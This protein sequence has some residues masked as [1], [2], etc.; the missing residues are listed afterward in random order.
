[1]KKY[2]KREKLLL[3][4]IIIL[5]GLF[6]WDFLREKKVQIKY[7]EDSVAKYVIYL[8]DDTYF[9]D[10]FNNKYLSNTIENIRVNFNYKAYF[11]RK[12]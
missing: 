6:C 5:F 7:T 10:D 1:M 9:K 3:V 8:N 4:V 12:G 11:N 2:I